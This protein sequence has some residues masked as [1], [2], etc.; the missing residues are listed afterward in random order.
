MDWT[1]TPPAEPGYYWHRRSDGD[2]A[3]LYDVWAAEDGYEPDGEDERGPIFRPR[4]EVLAASVRDASDK[5]RTV[6][7]VGGEWKGPLSPQ[8]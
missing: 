8:D 1:T 2:E 6:G 7:E 4:F 3:A 5:G